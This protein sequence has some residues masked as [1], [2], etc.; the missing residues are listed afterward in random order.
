MELKIVIFHA[1]LKVRD[2]PH[3]HT[4]DVSKEFGFIA[5]WET[6]G[7]HNIFQNP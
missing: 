2:M 3:S 6:T 4:K 5:S 1:V 7:L